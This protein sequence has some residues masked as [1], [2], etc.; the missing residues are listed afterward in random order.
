M[1]A[2]QKANRERF[3][4]VV[5]EAKKLR[6]KNPKLT[7]AQAVK[8]AWAIMYSKKRAGVG[9]VKKKAA[10]K[11]SSYHKDTKS[12]NVNI[13][14]MSGW[15]K[16]KTHIIEKNE[17]KV[18]DAKNVRVTRIAKGSVTRKPGTFRNFSTLKGI[19]KYKDSIRVSGYEPTKEIVVGKIGKLE[20]LKTLVP[21]VKL[22]ITRGK[23][24]KTDFVTSA[25]D[26]IDIFK[27]FITKNRVETQEFF[28]VAYLA[29]NLKVLGVY[30][31]SMGT[32][33]STTVDI[34]LIM[35]AAV[36]MGATNMILC[37]NHPSGNTQ[38]SEADKQITNNI[39][40]AAKLMD[41]RVL[42]HVILTKDGFYSFADNG[43]I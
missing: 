12:H 18:P 11:S 41:I 33:T 43:L 25:Q 27:K 28:A 16:G 15:K 42:D 2:K 37:H 1:T 24:T 35:A 14:V 4:K 22:R 19:D 3:K 21:E 29:T 23:K 10:K 8:Q 36:Q 9:A 40:K 34:R 31:A 26:S 32:L 17:G 20:T 6:K 13:R 5:A 30:V 7:Q 39:V 38:Y